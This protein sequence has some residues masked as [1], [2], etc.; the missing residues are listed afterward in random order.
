M[1][2]EGFAVYKSNCNQSPMKKS[3]GKDERHSFDIQTE[4]C[5]TV[6][7]LSIPSSNQDLL[8]KS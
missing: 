3:K 2:E 8:C 5:N 7:E 6:R 1:G 4:D